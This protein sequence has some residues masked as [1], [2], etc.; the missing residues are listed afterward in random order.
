[1][2]ER[3]GFEPTVVLLL[4]TLF[5]RADQIQSVG[6]LKKIKREKLNTGCAS[7]PMCYQKIIHVAQLDTYQILV[8]QNT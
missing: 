2:A 4:H 8:H 5:K 1:M 7:E 6:F 3:E